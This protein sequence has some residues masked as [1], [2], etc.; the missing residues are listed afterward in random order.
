MFH[1]WAISKHGSPSSSN[2]S[3][4]VTCKQYKYGVLNLNLNN[5]R[6]HIFQICVPL[7]TEV[8]WCWIPCTPCSVVA[9]SSSGNCTWN[10]PAACNF[11]YGGGQLPTTNWWDKTTLRWRQ[12]CLLHIMNK[13]KIA[14]YKILGTEIKTSH[15]E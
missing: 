2:N 14:K 12:V 6:I 4:I 7:Q 15:Y 11:K 8:T 5:P 10:K 13:N 9:R 3:Y 1:G